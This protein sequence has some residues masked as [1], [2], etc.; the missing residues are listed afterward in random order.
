GDA[1]LELGRYDEAE[2]A[3]RKLAELGEQGTIDAE[4]RWARLARL[5]GRT[6]TARAHLETALE[7]AREV[8]APAA[9]GWC[10]VQ[11][12]EIAFGRGEWEKA[13]KLYAEA[14]E[15]VP[16]SASALDHLAELRAA[17]GKYPE[18]I[19]LYGRA[20]ERSPR[21]ELH[22][23][24]GDLYAFMGKADEAR[25]WH[26]RARDAY[27]KSVGEGRVHYYH[28][29]AGLYADSMPDAA[30]ALEWAKKDLEL[31]KS[32]YALDAL[33]W[34]LHRGGRDAEALPVMK[35]AL[36]AGT[37][38]AHLYYHASLI[39]SGAG[40]LAAG[41]QLLRRCVAINPRYNAF[42]VHR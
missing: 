41:K 19:D 29:L 36:A 28:H 9:I 27:L 5:R 40:D 15:E 33:A 24:L 11:L 1:L 34:A 14:L 6:E 22:Q 30:A 26:T 37:E 21:P 18:A 7:R 12:G 2:A 35:E 16:D 32:V 38:D 31:R 20:I 39:A 13:E 17:Q 25:P 8:A 10:S 23:A 4:T 3:Y 42:H